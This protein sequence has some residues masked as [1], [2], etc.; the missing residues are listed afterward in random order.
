MQMTQK[1]RIAVAEKKTNTTAEKKTTATKKSAPATSRTATADKPAAGKKA[2]SEKKPTAAKKKAAE[3]IELPA[4]LEMLENELT[5]V[6]KQF[7]KVGEINPDELSQALDEYAL[8]STQFQAVESFLKLHQITVVS[9]PDDADDDVAPEPSSS[10]LSS[11]D[12]VLDD[13]T[14][15]LAGDI[16][17]VEDI[18]DS[19]PEEELKSAESVEMVLTTQPER[20]TRSSRRR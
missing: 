15:D 6:I 4:E 1:E 7:G 14:V 3:V 10:V 20:S 18:L 5:S 9:E 11:D 19:I 8:D 17:D 2:A 16:D 13:L 12:A